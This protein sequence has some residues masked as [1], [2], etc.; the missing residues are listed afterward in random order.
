[1]RLTGI[2]DGLHSLQKGWSVETVR[3][4]VRLDGLRR[5]RRMR[6]LDLIW[7]VISWA[8]KRRDAAEGRVPA[9][10]L[11]DQAPASGMTVVSLQ[12]VSAGWSGRKV[13]REVDLDLRPG[14]VTALMGRNGAGKAPLRIAR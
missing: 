12:R 13:L 10:P 8:R 2:A 14:E 11:P 7:F 6:A 9:S 3:N 5:D 1:M 4:S